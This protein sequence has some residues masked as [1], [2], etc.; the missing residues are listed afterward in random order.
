MNEVLEAVEAEP[1]EEIQ[2]ESPVE[3]TEEPKEEV[4]SWEDYGTEEEPEEPTDQVAEQPWDAEIKAGAADFATQAAMKV[5]EA[6][7]ELTGALAG[8]PKEVAQYAA[9]KF[10]ALPLNAKLAPQVGQAVAAYAIGLAVMKGK[11][12]AGDQRS[13]A[14]SNHPQVSPVEQSREAEIQQWTEAFMDADRKL[15]KAEA[16]KMAMEVV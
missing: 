2:E 10:A 15:T 16:R 12:P 3:I 4:V 11:I 8:Y 14:R 1:T 7:E 5:I 9:K 6:R 13:A